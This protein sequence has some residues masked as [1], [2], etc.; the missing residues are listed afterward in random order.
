MLNKI[1]VS[2]LLFS[3]LHATGSMDEGLA[4]K[5]QDSNRLTELAGKHWRFTP[6]DAPEFSSATFDDSA[7][8]I[9]NINNE[10][11]LQ[12][13]NYDGVGWFR[14]PLI[15]GS[16]F[17]GKQIGLLVPTIAAAHEIYLNGKKI[18]GRG[19]IGAHGSLE[20]A[21]EDV[22]LYQIPT[23]LLSLN[24]TNI[25]AFRIR[26]V[27][28][29]GG[30]F[31]D[32]DFLIGE[33]SLL[34]SRYIRSQIIF[35]LLAGAFFIIGLYYA[36]L[37]FS[38]HEQKAPLYFSF[39][40][41]LLGLFTLGM[42][43]LSYNIIDS[44][45]FHLICIH[46]VILT[47]PFWL[48]NFGFDF[49]EKKRNKLLKVISILSIADFCLFLPVL[50][51]QALFKLYLNSVFP[52]AFLLVAI[53]LLY[54]IFI[55]YKAIREKKAGAKIIA[56][57]FVLYF[58]CTTN[59]MLSYLN[60]INSVRLTDFGFLIITFC[61]A[62]ALAIQIAKVYRDKEKAQRDALESQ[63]LLADSYAR[64]VPRQFLINL[65]KDSILDVRLGD[66]VQ[67]SMTIM[68]ADIRSF[69]KLSESMTPKENFNFI[70]S[71]L[72][73]MSPIIQSHGGFIDKFL[74]D[75]IMA[76][77]ENDTDD[78]L[79]AAIE[80]QKYIVEY[81]QYRAN[82]KYQA[83]SIGVGVHTGN[84]MLGTIGSDLRMDGTV[85]SDAV[86]LASRIEGLTKLYEVKIATSEEALQTVK[87][88]GRYH[89]RFIDRVRVVGKNQ[90]VGVIEIMDGDG[91]E[92]L[93]RKMDTLTDFNEA[94]VR[95]YDRDFDGAKTLLNKVLGK[96]PNDRA[97][98]I[99]LER[100]SYFKA[101]GLPPD[102]EG[103]E[104]L[105]AK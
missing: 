98:N 66:Q 103:V 29:V 41:I 88:L 79:N 15:I 22:Y 60:I 11:R 65:G 97:A 25:L 70:N 100:S 63:T 48:L 72:K 68:F 43:G 53:S 84:L 38:R 58:F 62:I 64:F 18:G 50:F 13:Y 67:K 92:S 101:H 56:S 16:E 74:G 44:Y 37:Y 46:A 102:W 6:A 42:K 94:L 27:D 35:G 21:K 45:L 105:T 51:N 61:M 54:F 82:K 59:D 23:D 57:G 39:F 96:N 73:R 90:P 9:L 19:V 95:Y 52:V 7:W 34:Y 36:V 99:Y 83:I 93:Q 87:D 20:R 69:T 71:Y 76:L 32:L 78:S 47:L 81:N 26:S 55:N 17:Q 28:G 4:L 49:F 2:F 40:S 8:K 77:F 14:R 1:S 85:I 33:Y 30:V 89:H 86:N 80:M 10:W 5:L 24:G 75:G 12:G 3:M 91:A 104:S 31:G